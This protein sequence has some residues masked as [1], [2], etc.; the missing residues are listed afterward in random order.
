MGHNNQDSGESRAKM[1][2]AASFG[3]FEEIANS[4]IHNT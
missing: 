3:G 4:L 2:K 1:Q